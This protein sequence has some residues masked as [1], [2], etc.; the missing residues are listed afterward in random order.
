MKDLLTRRAEPAETVLTDSYQVYEKP[1]TEFAEHYT[2]DH[3]AKQHARWQDDVR[4]H[5]KTVEGSFSQ[6]KRSLD[7]MCHHV[8]DKHLARYLAELDY[9]CNTRKIKDG[10]R[11]VVAVQQVAGRD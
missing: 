2:I 1:G 3:T 7:G 9:R 6:L 4:V 8:S 5:T 10:E 11:M